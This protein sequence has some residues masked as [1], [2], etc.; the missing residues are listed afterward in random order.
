MRINFTLIIPI[1]RWVRKEETSQMRSRSWTNR[2]NDEI[3]L[4]SHSATFIIESTFTQLSL[5]LFSRHLKINEN[6]SIWWQLSFFLLFWLFVSCSFSISF[7]N[8]QI[9]AESCQNKIDLLH[10]FTWHLF[11]VVAKEMEIV[12]SSFHMALDIYSIESRTLEWKKKYRNE[13]CQNNSQLNQRER[14]KLL[15]SIKCNNSSNV[16]NKQQPHQASYREFPVFTRKIPNWLILFLF[17]I[18]KKERKIFFSKGRWIDEG[19]FSLKERKI[20]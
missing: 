6:D 18:F 16:G 15:W 7:E 8:Q 1:G 5:S 3:R 20:S 11:S 12:V 17:S 19:I 14:K 9:D 10:K 13:K 4:F 2:G